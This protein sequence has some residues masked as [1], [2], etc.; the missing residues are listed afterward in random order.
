MQQ[1]VIKLKSIITKTNGGTEYSQSSQTDNSDKKSISTSIDNSLH[2]ELSKLID[3]F[4]NMELDDPSN[5][6][7]MSTIE[8]VIKAFSSVND[9]DNLLN[10]SVPF[11]PQ[12]TAEEILERNKSKG[13]KKAPNNFMIY[14]MEYTKELKT[15]NIS[16]IN[17]F[18]MSVLAALKWKS[19]PPEV[20]QAYKDISDK[21]QDSQNNNNININKR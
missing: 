14:R 9:A 4:E 19:E 13:R 10:I 6:S 12:I 8:K 1:V 17:L 3:D 5:S 20:K 18:N 15:K 7:N 16:N 11:P 2:K 21:V